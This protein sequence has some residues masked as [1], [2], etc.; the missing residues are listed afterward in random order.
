MGVL[1]Y[2]FVCSD[3]GTVGAVAVDAQGHVAVATSTG[4]ISG[5]L[6][7]RVGDTPLPG[8]HMICECKIRNIEIQLSYTT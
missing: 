6:V 4:G 2:I 7:G 8:E 1:L 5:K 3:V